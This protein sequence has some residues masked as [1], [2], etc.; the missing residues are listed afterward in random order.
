M[1]GLASD[2][3]WNPGESDGALF[4]GTDPEGFLAA[5]R[6]NEPPLGFISAVRYGSS[7]GFIGLYLVEPAHR[8]GPA[9]LLLARAAIRMMGDR[10]VGTDGVLERVEQYERIGRFTFAHR[11]AR[12]ALENRLPAPDQHEI[13]GVEQVPAD[14]LIRFDTAHFGEDR[15]GFLFPWVSQPGATALAW[16]EGEQLRGYGVIRP[17]NGPWKIGPLFAETPAIAEGLFLAL[18]AAAGPGGPVFLD[19]PQPNAAAMEL[20]QRHGMTEVFA[21]ARLYR[22]G[23]STLP[24]DR[25]FGITSFE[26]G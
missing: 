2:A 17:C 18:Q 14:R 13:V 26:L 5:A 19:V 10:K 15:A 9:G 4:H 8:G 12:Y 23:E 25:I 6:E 11:N 7:L 24:L 16:V 1:I 22:N 3:G 20:V 21:T